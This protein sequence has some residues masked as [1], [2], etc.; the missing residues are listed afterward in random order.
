MTRY[1][2]C[3]DTAKLIRKELKA[4]FPDIKFSVRS[5]TYAGGA[6]ISIEWTD[7]PTEKAVERVIRIF[8]GATFDGSIDLKSYT[9]TEWEGEKVHFGADYVNCFRKMSRAFVE[10]IAAQFCKRFGLAAN[11]IKVEGKDD[12]AWVNPNNLDHSETHWFYDLLRNTDAKDMHRA[13]EAQDERVAREHAEWEA[14]SEKEAREHAE[15]EMKAERERVAREQVE[16]EQWKLANEL[17]LREQFRL[18][19]QEQERSA[20]AEAERQE[21]Q[22]QAEEKARRERQQ[23]EQEERERRQRGREQFRSTQHTVLAS[24]DRSLAYLGLTYRATRTDI[25]RAF[26]QKVKAASDGKGGYTIDMDFLVKVKEK[27]LG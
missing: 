8:Q 6:S 7:G 10:A 24:R 20:R 2:S 13:Y 14:H 22:R 17:L 9:E 3:A 18:W 26:R 12:G 21:A 15:A 25:M 1:I 19:K 5:S 16:F 4:N 23:R 11:T 27:A